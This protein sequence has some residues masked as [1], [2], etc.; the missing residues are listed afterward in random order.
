MPEQNPQEFTRAEAR[1]IFA[2]LLTMLGLAIAGGT[3]LCLVIS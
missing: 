2:G 3:T 1:L